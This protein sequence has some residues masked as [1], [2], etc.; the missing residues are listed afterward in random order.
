MLAGP[1][2]AL[3]EARLMIDPP[4]A[5]AMPGW[6]ARAARRV[7]ARL[8]AGRSR[9]AA[10]SVSSAAWRVSSA[11][12]LISTRVGPVAAAAALTDDARAWASRTSTAENHDPASRA[13]KAS[14]A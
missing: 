10:A 5:A 3:M 4:P 2:S 1:R 12:L 6:T 9:H 8:T 11:T 13:D 7:G 14:P